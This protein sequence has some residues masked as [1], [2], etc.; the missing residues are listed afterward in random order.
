[1]ILKNNPIKT[2]VITSPAALQ[3]VQAKRTQAVFVI[4]DAFFIGISSRSAG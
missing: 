1:M 4:V 2:A 3:E